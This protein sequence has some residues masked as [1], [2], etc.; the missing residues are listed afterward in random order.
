[1]SRILVL[2]VI[3]FLCFSCFIPALHAADKNEIGLGIVLG[4]P[5]GLNTQFFWSNNS[6]V[7]VTAAWSLGDWL[8]LA[9]D[10][11]IYN[12]LADLPRE[13]KWYY[14]LG[15]YATFPD[16][17]D[18]TFGVRVPFGI[19]YHIPYTSMDTWV[20]AAPGLEL[21]EDTEAIIHAGVGIT[22]WLK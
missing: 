1:M 5:T 16:D 10:Y 8:T 13:Y 11:Q 20:E 12:Y 2:T 7:D 6:A 9:A 18:L 14:G 19:K 22:W 17:K 4:E 3:A 21:V 15:T